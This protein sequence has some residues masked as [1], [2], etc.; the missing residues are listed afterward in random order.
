MPTRDNVFV[1][2]GRVAQYVLGSYSARRLGLQTSANADGVHNLTVDANAGDLSELV[3]TMDKGLLVTELMGQGVNGLTGDYSRGA[4]GFWVEHGEIQ[5]PVE[6]ITIAS[7]L[8]DMFLS[9]RAIG[10]D[11]NPNISTRCG[12]ILIEQMMVAG[13]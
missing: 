9:M 7:N 6:E 2:D 10:N 3:K 11:F 13:N 8:K 5:Y 4:T 1:N 12:S